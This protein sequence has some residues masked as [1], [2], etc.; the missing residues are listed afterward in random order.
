MSLTKR[1]GDESERNVGR[2][3][4]ELVLLGQGSVDIP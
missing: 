1:Y 3:G 2:P 4:G